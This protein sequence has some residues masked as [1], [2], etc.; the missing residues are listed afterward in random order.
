MVCFKNKTSHNVLCLCI[1]IAI[2]PI[3]VGGGAK[4]SD[5]FVQSTVFLQMNHV[6]FSIRFQG[7]SFTCHLNNV[8][9][10]AGSD[11]VRLLYTYLTP[12]ICGCS[13]GARTSDC[14]IRLR[15]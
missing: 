8:I 5:A 11:V 6:H 14:R 2:V 15:T 13:P 4:S 7:S 3:V 12:S 9:S 1:H 10:T